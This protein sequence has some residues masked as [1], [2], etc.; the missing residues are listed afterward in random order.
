MFVGLVPETGHCYQLDG[1]EVVVLGFYYVLLGG[2]GLVQIFK[3]FVLFF[4]P[5]KVLALRQ[6][7]QAT[8]VHRE[9]DWKCGIMPLFQSML[10]KWF[11]L[12]SQNYFL[13][14]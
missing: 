14:I 7:V 12:I 5:K 4:S 3:V 1:L 6:E 9:Q 8:F 10:E 2:P 11:G 13:V